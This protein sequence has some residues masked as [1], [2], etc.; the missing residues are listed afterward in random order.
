M[1][2]F[3]LQSWHVWYVWYADMPW[4]LHILKT[5]DAPVSWWLHPHCDWTDSR[6]NKC[7]SVERVHFFVKNMWI[8]YGF[9][10][11]IAFCCHKFIYKF[12]G[13][14]ISSEG[15]GYLLQVVF[16][17]LAYVFELGVK[18]CGAKKSD[19]VFNDSFDKAWHAK[20]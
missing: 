3:P 1:N 15:H 9:D 16:G 17:Q 4:Q 20:H 8:L 14:S 7:S 13:R 6:I 11:F 5:G 18:R 2:G 19:A 12:E 10:E